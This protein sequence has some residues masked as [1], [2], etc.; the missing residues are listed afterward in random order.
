[1]DEESP[2][3]PDF[4]SSDWIFERSID[5]YWDPTKEKIKGI[6]LASPLSD[7]DSAARRILIKFWFARA[8]RY[9]SADG[10]LGGTV[11]R[12]YNQSDI[13]KM[14]GP[15]ES[16]EQTW[17]QAIFFKDKWHVLESGDIWEYGFD[18]SQDKTLLIGLEL[19]LNGWKVA[20]L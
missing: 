4:E 3:P 14:W 12:P 19:H 16:D 15:L 7:E 2:D 17:K 5:F 10:R 13:V 11:I 1:M 8:S 20:D 18:V 9:K 6:N